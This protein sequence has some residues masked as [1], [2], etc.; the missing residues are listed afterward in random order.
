M[1][2]ITS[3]LAPDAQADRHAGLDPSRILQTA[4]AFWASK[5]LL[6]A[7]SSRLFTVLGDG[8]MTAQELGA[9]LDLHPRGTF[10]FFDALVAL[11]F[12]HRDGDG[13]E[14]R[15][16]N[17]TEASTFLDR[18]RPTYVGGICEMLD[19][20][21]FGFWNDL[22]TALRTGKPQ[23]EIKREGKPFFEGLYASPARLEEFL[24]AMAGVQAGNFHALAEKFDFARYETLADVGGALG[25]LSV[26]V[27]RRHPHLRLTTFDLPPVAPLA[28]RNV[29]A[30]G[31]ASRIA[32][33]SGD[34][35]RDPLPRADVV[36]M[37]NI[38]HDWN[39][40]TKKLLIRKA[41]EALPAGGAF[42]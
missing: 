9:K 24:H 8:A 26:I 2:A 41:Y 42:V 5:V 39:L 18:N 6:T 13:P 31:M 17:T 32:V 25:T 23:S 34:F 11:G 16:R 28:T 20:R 19:S 35:F 38:L 7:V 10:D 21:L 37:G 36:T 30:A 29:E 22:G 3:T 12:L 27:G 4:T 14:A 1:E 33:A 15:Y 40:E